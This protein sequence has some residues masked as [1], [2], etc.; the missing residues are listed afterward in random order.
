MYKLPPINRNLKLLLAMNSFFA[1]ANG[2]LMPVL[3]PYLLHLG[4]KGGDVGLLNGITGLSMAVSLVPAAYLADA[5]GRKP[6]ALA[7]LST[8]PLAILLLLTGN[9]VALVASFALNGVLSAAAN[10]S[11]NPLFADS[12]EKDQH[13][14]AVFSFSQILSL[15]FSSVGAALT[16]PLLSMSTQLGG[17]V[18]SYRAAFLL[19]ALFFTASIFL[20]LGV[21]ESR[22]RRTER[23][24]LKVSP[25]SLKLAGLGGLIAFG[26]GI[27]IWN[28]NYWFSR[29]YGVEA[30]ELGALSIAGNLV[31][32]ATTALAPAFSSKLGTLSAVVLLQ[33]SSIPLFLMVALSA[34]FI[35]AAAFYTLRSAIMNASNPLVSSLQMRLVKPEERARMSMLN[36][37]A[38]QVAGAAGAMLGGYLMDAWLDMPI[39]ITCVIYLAQTAL[40][41]AALRPHVTNRR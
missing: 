22:G 32:V 38:W 33:L 19:C 15:I 24:S 2:L 34:S 28:I 14:D 17:V 5:K 40:F 31:M 12:V 10:V 11:L 23:F 18:G 16:W 3:Y 7:A 36:V 25:V 35:H 20:L 30:A 37:L 21:K 1:L 9:P 41:Y 13:M 27:G 26:A 8:S 6:L 4:L 29:K 39:Y